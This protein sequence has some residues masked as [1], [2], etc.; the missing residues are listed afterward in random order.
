MRSTTLN[1]A[2]RRAIDAET[3]AKRRGKFSCIHFR[4]IDALTH[5]SIMHGSD[6]DDASSASSS[7]DIDCP[8]EQLLD[9]K[10]TGDVTKASTI[11]LLSK[12]SAAELSRTSEMCVCSGKK[13]CRFKKFVDCDELWWPK[14]AE[15]WYEAGTAPEKPMGK[16]PKDKKTWKNAYLAL[17][18]EDGPT[19]EE[20]ARREAK[21]AKREA[22]LAKWKEEN[23][24]GA[25]G[26]RGRAAGVG[27][28]IA[29]NDLSDKNAMR[30][31][32][33]SV[34]AKPKGKSARGSYVPAFA[35]ED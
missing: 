14:C 33:K 1:D 12:M 15:A 34:R 3:D 17:R 9:P 26:L 16:P 8:L 22:M 11:A 21:L 4:R 7:I 20:V 28:V 19:P 18:P 35:G 29:P 25:G 10:Y 2:T 30:D 31:F 27:D 6:D 13:G 32:Y 24:A 23:L 5:S